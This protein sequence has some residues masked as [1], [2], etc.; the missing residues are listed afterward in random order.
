[1]QGRIKSMNLEGRKSLHENHQKLFELS[2]NKKS[3]KLSTNDPVRHYSKLQL[4]HRDGKV[5]PSCKKTRIVPSRAGEFP[6][7]RP[8]VR[9]LACIS[10]TKDFT[11]KNGH[12]NRSGLVPSSRSP[13]NSTITNQRTQTSAVSNSRSPQCLSEKIAL[14]KTPSPCFEDGKKTSKSRRALPVR[15]GLRGNQQQPLCVKQKEHSKRTQT[16]SV[17]GSINKPFDQYLESCLE[18]SISNINHEKGS[19]S[20]YKTVLFGWIFML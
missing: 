9:C 17:E 6:S 11:V 15:Q 19:S 14:T 7:K 5:Q 4:S 20:V 2:E 12:P 10:G 16:I 1:M 8:V 3:Q 18:E 13:Q